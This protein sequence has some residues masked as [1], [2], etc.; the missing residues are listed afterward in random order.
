MRRAA[1]RVE[2]G[3]GGERLLL[4]LGLGWAGL[5][6]LADQITKAV[7]AA[8]FELFESLPVID[9]FFSIT[10][11]TNRGAAWNIFEGHT[12]LLLG[13]AAAVT[14]AAVW[15]IRSLAEG[16]AERYI[17]VF[18]LLS[19]V[20]GNSIDRIWR[21][22]VVDFFAFT[23]GSYR[24]PVFNVADSAICVGVAVFVLSYSLRKNKKAGAAVSGEAPAEGSDRGQ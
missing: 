7:V 9:G 8:R 12:W 13:F 19:G 23:F 10:Y 3:S 5:L 4:G 1:R 14:I 2:P 20:V 6:L 21:G 22:A 24:Y 17:A 11:V 18:T 16:Y 15:F